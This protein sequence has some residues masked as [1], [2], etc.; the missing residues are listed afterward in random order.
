[1]KKL[2]SFINTYTPL[3]CVLI[4]ICVLSI[5]GVQQSQA[6]QVTGVKISSLTQSV[7]SVRQ[8]LK[9]S[10]VLENKTDDFL[11]NLTLNSSLFRANDKKVEGASGS[12]LDNT[13]YV[14]SLSSE[15]VQVVPQAT[16]RGT[17]DIPLPKDL[18]TGNYFLS[19]QIQNED[20]TL[21]LSW[22]T[23]KSIAL[24]GTGGYVYIPTASVLYKNTE[25][26][27][28]EGKEQQVIDG[29]TVGFARGESPRFDALVNSANVTVDYE[30]VALSEAGNNNGKDIVYASSTTIKKQ[31]VGDIEYNVFNIPAQPNIVAGPYDV[32]IVLRQGTKNLTTDVITARWL[33][34]G[35]VGRIGEVV[36][37]T[38][39]LHKG[40]IDLLVDIHGKN[41]QGMQVELK[42][43]FKNESGGE[44]L[45]LTEPI[46]FSTDTESIQ[47]DFSD[48]K[49]DLEKKEK[50]ASI[51]LELS[52][53]GTLLDGTIYSVQSD[54]EFIKT[55][56]KN[57]F[58]LIVV[59]IIIL[60]ILALLIHMFVHKNSPTTTTTTALLVVLIASAV[61]ISLSTQNVFAERRTVP[62]ATKTYVIVEDSV[63]DINGVSRLQNIS[64]G[65]S[66]NLGACPQTVTVAFAGWHAC[67]HCANGINISMTLNA[68]VFDSLTGAT[69]TNTSYAQPVTKFPGGMG[70]NFGTPIFTQTL[71]LTNAAPKIEYSVRGAS[72]NWGHGFCLGSEKTSATQTITCTPFQSGGTTPPTGSGNCPVDQKFCATS[73]QCIAN[74]QTC[75]QACGTPTVPAGGAVST[76]TPNMC[77]PGFTPVA[78]SIFARPSTNK[79]YW[80]CMP[81]GSAVTGASGGQCEASCPQGTFYEGSKG[82]CATDCPD[83]CPNID[84]AQT[85][86]AEYTRDDNGHCQADGVIKYFRARPDTHE[87]SCPGFWETAVGPAAWMDCKIN[88]T[89]V[90][91]NNLD[92]SGVTGRPL[93]SG[94]L[95]TLSCDIRLTEDDTLIK[96]VTAN[97][98]CFKPGNIIEN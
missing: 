96:T 70:N 36:S 52:T 92:V 84:G 18:D 54:Q 55:I 88:G 12:L 28:L 69:F 45:S 23:E 21:G 8:V 98:R 13:E 83:W 17:L 97:T 60:L 90:N 80:S 4:L 82:Y 78:S 38:N 6:Q 9:V 40:P 16:Y 73:G 43:V 68:K 37:G 85:S 5:V 26:R 3:I 34:D 65:P 58:S 25:Y 63:A 74:S 35:F 91:A 29:F 48:I 87:T 1:M 79:W 19:F 41:G 27:L 64:Q 95:H 33:V 66:G 22:I 56:N 53:Q 57:T 10:Y 51:A 77:A 31:K 76:L 62:K 30:V 86:V 81:T 59:A 2:A 11:N 24:K 72:S 14:L 93:Q 20:G 47:V 7:D 94:R 89:A 46:V 44:I 39:V 61:F 67:P 42:A 75:P 50:V 15:I 71:T 32:R 49:A